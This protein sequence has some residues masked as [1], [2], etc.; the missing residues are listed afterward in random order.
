[1]RAPALAHWRQP[2]VQPIVPRRLF[3]KRRHARSESRS[4]PAF[5]RPNGRGGSPAGGFLFGSEREFLKGMFLHIGFFGKPD[6]TIP[7]R[8]HELLLVKIR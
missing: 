2:D 4:H 7:D 1:M 3:G 8:S 6:N 5:D